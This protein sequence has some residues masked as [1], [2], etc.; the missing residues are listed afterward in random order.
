MKRRTPASLLAALAL[1]GCTAYP[2]S[3]TPGPRPDPVLS[4]FSRITVWPMEI[5]LADPSYFAL[6]TIDDGL[7]MQYPLVPVSRLESIYGA[8]V[9]MDNDRI[10]EF[11]SRHPWPHPDS[12]PDPFSTPAE[13]LAAGVHELQRP[14]VPYIVQDLTFPQPCMYFLL[15]A[16][17][18]P[19]NINGIFD[20]EWTRLPRSPREIS[21][22][23][24]EAVGLD[25]DGSGWSAQLQQGRC[26]RPS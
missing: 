7:S 3:L 11:R 18:T 23:V 2:V 1:A 24:V 5:R 15:L 9:D 16:S 26:G 14:Y 12:V 6:F 10:V 22:A 8:R 17:D 21:G 4:D 20:L 25:P 19:L 13:Q